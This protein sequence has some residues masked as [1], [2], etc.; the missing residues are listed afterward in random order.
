MSQRSFY[1]SLVLVSLFSAIVVF[2]LT[3]LPALQSSRAFSLF[4]ILVFI[5]LSIAMYRYGIIS[6]KSE[7][8]NAF[9]SVVMGF[10]VAKMLLCLGLIIA[11]I[12]VIQPPTRFFIYPFLIIY[13]I[14]TIFET[15]FMMKISKAGK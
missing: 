9:T 8:R 5:W 11:Y 15:F 12:Q 2:L 7:D 4:S 6:A 10:I 1:T 14:Y 13:L 3:L